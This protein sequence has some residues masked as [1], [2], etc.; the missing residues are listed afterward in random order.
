M[1]HAFKVYGKVRGQARPRV[2]RNGRHTYKP[3]KDHEYDRA[4]REAYVNSGGGYFGDK[5]LVM[6]VISHR[7]L[8]NSKPKKITSE[9]DIFRPDASNVLKAVEDALNK[10]AYYD[11]SQIVCSIPLKAP[12]R[13]GC[14]EHL[15]VIISDEVDEELLEAKIRGVIS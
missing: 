9:S 12:R 4:I 6:I 7:E 10:L 1:R 15:E 13:R 11:D 14:E 5:P 8:P 2:T 3:P